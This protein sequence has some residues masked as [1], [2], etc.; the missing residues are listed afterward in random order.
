MKNREPDCNEDGDVLVVYPPGE[1]DL[2]AKGWA[3]GQDG[4]DPY[5]IYC[6]TK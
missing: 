4:V 2:K 1:S 6:D 5:S 3:G